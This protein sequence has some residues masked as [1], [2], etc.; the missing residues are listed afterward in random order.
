M[1]WATKRLAQKLIAIFVI[2]AILGV[3][4]F[5]TAIIIFFLIVGVVFWRTVRR[6]EN[7]ETERVFEF[8][9]AADE[10]LRDEGR[11]WYGFEI[12]EVIDSG[13][14][15]VLSL[16]DC[17]PLIRFALG[18]LCHRVSD[19][20]TAVEH[21]SWLTEDWFSNEVHQTSPSPQLRRYVETLRRIEREP[22][23]AP[24][25]L[26]AVRNLERSRRKRAADLLAESRERLKDPSTQCHT[27]AHS[28]SAEGAKTERTRKAKPLSLITAPPPISE[29]LHEIY[30]SEDKKTA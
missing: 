17:P 30:Q 8:Y 13:E 16:P 28:V 3:I 22:A 20:E 15:V 29:V 14:K 10:V 12:A 6:S 27:T 25:T 4:G 1:S 18:A 23:M 19:Y 21:L 7:Q 9:I 11:Q 2:V 26:A 24:Q 5:S